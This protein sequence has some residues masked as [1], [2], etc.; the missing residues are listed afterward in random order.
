MGGDIKAR[1]FEVV[2]SSEETG[3]TGGDCSR[4]V[5]AVRKVST[6]LDENLKT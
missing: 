2:A 4:E 6:V 5:G 3:E 1:I